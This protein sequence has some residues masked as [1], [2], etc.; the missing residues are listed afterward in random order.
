AVGAQ[1]VNDASGFMG[2]FSAGDGAGKEKPST[3]SAGSAVPAPGVGVVGGV[4]AAALTGT[5]F[6]TT[7]TSTTGV[8]TAVP[9]GGALDEAATADLPAAPPSAADRPAV[10]TAVPGPGGEVTTDGPHTS[11]T[12]LPVSSSSFFQD[13]GGAS[14]ASPAAPSPSPT[15]GEAHYS[16]DFEDNASLFS[17]V[18]S[19]SDFEDN[20][21][22]FSDV[23]SLSDAGDDSDVWSVASDDTVVAE[24]DTAGPDTA[25]AGSGV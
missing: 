21:S 16:G 3:V 18:S 5:N 6:N 4:A 20:A 24:P 2:K 13:T 25:G 12:A 22:L 9:A 23:S 14:A 11:G 10:T 15:V 7:D 8:S 17:D 1:H 19:L